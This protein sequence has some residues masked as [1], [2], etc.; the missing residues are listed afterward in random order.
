MA[1]ATQIG[2][3][4][5]TITPASLVKIIRPPDDSQEVFCFA[6]VLYF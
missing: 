6:F 5:L 3:I 2:H 1:Y 4:E